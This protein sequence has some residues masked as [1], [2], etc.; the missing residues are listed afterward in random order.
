LGQA[1]SYQLS[2]RSPI[3]RDYKWQ[4]FFI[5]LVFIS[6][7]VSRLSSFAQQPVDQVYP[8]LDAANSR[9]IYFS[10]ACR[11]FGMVNLSPDT[12]LDGAWGSGYVYDE[13]EIKGFSHVHAWQM[14]GVLTMPVVSDKSIKHIKNNYH[15]NFSHDEEVVAPGYHKVLLERFGIEAELTS[16]KRVGFHRY[17]YPDGVAAKIVLDLSENLGPSKMAGGF[18]R[19]VN[20][21]E[22]RGYVINERT[23]RR[24]LPVTVYFHIVV[25]GEIERLDGWKG[26]QALKDVKRVK[27]QN[28]GAII[29]FTEESGT[30]I[31]MKVGISYVSMKQAKLNVDSELPDW[32]FDAVVTESKDE[33]NTWLSRFTVEGGSEEDRRRFYT[34][35]WHSLLGRRVIN[36]VNAKYA[37]YTSG[38]KKVKQ[39]PLDEFGEPKFEHHNSDSFWGAQWTLNTLWSLVYPEKVSD[40]CNSFLQ[41][42]EDGGLIPRGPSG[43]NYTYVMTGAS[44]T[45]FFVSAYMKGIRDWDVELAYEGLKKNHLPGGLMGKAGYEHGTAQGGGIE[46]YI[47]MGYVPYPHPRKLR[48]FHL[49]GAG[50]TLEYAFQ[51]F[52]LAQLA[53]SLGHDEDYE[54]FMIRSKNYENLWDDRSGFFHPR[55]RQGLW[56]GPFDPYAHAIGFV[57]SNAA[58]A[59]WFVPHDYDGLARLMGGQD[60]LIE[61]LNTSFEK[62]A[63]LGFTAGK[64]HDQELNK[65]FRRIP[66]N[67]GNQPSM[68]T[69]YIFN[70]VGAP[71]L[72]Q[73]WSRAVIDSVYTGLTPYVGYNGDE[74]QGL[75]GSLAVLMKIGLFQLDG[76]TTEDPV[77]QIGSPIFDYIEF[78]LDPDYYEG[79]KFVIRVINNSKENVYI[80]SLK[81]NGEPLD[82]FYLL[83]SEIVQGAELELVMGSEAKDEGKVMEGDGR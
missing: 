27:G 25:D 36:D 11:P 6:P 33:W 13:E 24:P 9:W 60:K 51:D 4:A 57:E 18:I 59:V 34:D 15:S 82:R 10:S 56:V 40:F 32:D 81:L 45:P 74:D 2:G 80:Q 5:L 16:T 17:T 58:Q 23:V 68:Q 47:K 53:K 44:S 22:L 48:A 50:Q 65:Q 3:Y 54:I 8:L 70:A 64:S 77:Y 69:A 39:L 19:Q 75:M 35:L 66:I 49:A 73:K 26:L 20:E 52:T 72:T 83:H 42:Y 43:G 30:S 38:N 62:A 46:N 7:F 55:N 67:Y 79:A 1:I 28:P 41:Y 31:Q 76:G 78:D 29:T 63:D 71:W 12:K 14:A 61:R 21:H 37:Y